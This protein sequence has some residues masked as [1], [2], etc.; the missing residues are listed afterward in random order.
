MS[1]DAEISSKKETPIWKNL[2]PRFFTAVALAGIVFLPLY[3][4]GWIWAIMVALIAAI[5]TWEWVSMSDPAPTRLAYILP[6]IGTLIT[7]YYWQMEFRLYAVLAIVIA[8][9]FAAIERARRGGLLWAG[10][11]YLYIII[12]SL[13]M[14]WLRGSEAGFLAKGFQHLGFIIMV[15]IAADVGAYF[16]GSFFKGPKMAPRL[17]PNKTWSG[18]FS[19]LLF[20]ASMGAIIGHFIGFGPIGAIAFAIPLAIASVMGD[21]LESGLK[22][23]LNVK[24][25]SGILPGHGG[26]LDRL[27][28]LM[29]AAAFAAL[30]LS[31]FP[32]LWPA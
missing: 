30:S 8:A 19:G 15:V 20:A 25:A 6:I 32:G 29:M 3:Y 14:I 24:D 26:L 31:L 9:L 5:V 27:D 17:S 2:G 4:G 12:P 28:S 23:V 1:I 16:G 22:R 18:F 7:L 11:G 21:F 13:L 10:L